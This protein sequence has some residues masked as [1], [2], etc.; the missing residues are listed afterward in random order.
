MTQMNRPLAHPAT[1]KLIADGVVAAYVHDM[2]QRHA[3]AQA[4]AVS[5]RRADPSAPRPL[6]EPSR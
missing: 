2:S 6:D 1:A 4:P 3:R 5:R